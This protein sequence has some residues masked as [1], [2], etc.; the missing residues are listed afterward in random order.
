M[1]KKGFTTVELIVSF[2]IVTIILTSL[3]GFTVNYRDKVKK[4]EIR[5]KL[6]DFKN[7]ITK[8]VYD[9]IIALNYTS[10]AACVGID[11]CVNFV[12]STGNSHVLKIENSCEQ[13]NCISSGCTINK[14]GVYLVY[15]DIR[16]LLPESNLNRYYKKNLDEDII[17]S[18]SVCG[19]SEFKLQ[20]YNN[21]IYTLKMN[22]KHYL[23]ND[24]FDIMLTVN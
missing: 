23:L 19:L 1:N 17:I 6:Y 5:T 3:V 13:I 2:M 12:D 21:S 16:Y 7:S 14:C 20:A 24:D 9:D 11:N 18:Q 8:I 22:F 10:I 15:N 4:E